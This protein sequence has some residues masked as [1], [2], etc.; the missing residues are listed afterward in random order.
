MGTRLLSFPHTALARLRLPPLS[1]ALD[2]FNSVARPLSRRS[3]STMPGPINVNPK[4]VFSLIPIPAL[5]GGCEVR[6][7]GLLALSCAGRARFVA[8]PAR[9]HAPPMN[10]PPPAPRPGGPAHRFDTYNKT[11]SAHRRSSGWR[12]PP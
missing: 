1:V 6:V 5:W 4:D 9:A 2:Q 7:L 11:L 12:R 8:L 3:T 10:S